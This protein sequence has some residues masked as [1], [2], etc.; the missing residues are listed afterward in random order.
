VMSGLSMEKSCISIPI[1]E[2]SNP[3]SQSGNCS[4]EGRKD[5]A[6]LLA[7]ITQLPLVKGKSPLVLCNTNLMD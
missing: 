2:S 1:F 5:Q 4:W 3:W 7:I 6:V